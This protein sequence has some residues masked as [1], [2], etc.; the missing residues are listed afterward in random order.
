M[1]NQNVA[2][3]NFEKLEKGPL[4]VGTAKK[5]VLAELGLP[6]DKELDIVLWKDRLSYIEKHKKDFSSEEEY[7][8]HLESIPDIINDPDY[9]GKHPKG[10]SIEYVKR[11]DKVVIVAVR[12]KNTGPLAIRTLYPLKESQV[13]SYLNSGRM[14]AM[15][16]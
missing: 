3:L 16:K 6:S 14:K 7:F 9:I 4:V 15:E 2:K 11:L 12:I 10:G 8:A 13:K 1:T 5:E